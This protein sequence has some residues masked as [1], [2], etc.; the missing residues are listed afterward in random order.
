MNGHIVQSSLDVFIFK[1][2]ITFPAFCKVAFHF[3]DRIVFFKLGVF[4]FFKKIN[5]ARHSAKYNICQRNSV[6]GVQI[7]NRRVAGV[8]H[9]N[10]FQKTA[11][12][13]LHKT[14][15]KR[16][17]LKRKIIKRKS[18]DEFFILSVQIF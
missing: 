3:I 17:S 5:S 15:H 6:G 2:K 12:I 4:Q 14:S 10:R 16:F 9:G 8:L 18:H 11:Y 7:T 13:L 1:R